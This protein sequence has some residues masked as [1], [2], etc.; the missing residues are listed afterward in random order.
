MHLLAPRG[1][2]SFSKTVLSSGGESLVGLLKTA[3][4]LCLLERHAWSEPLSDDVL[5]LVVSFQLATEE[6]KSFVNDLL[7]NE[8]NDVV[9]S[10]SALC[11]DPLSK[12][13]VSLANRVPLCLNTKNKREMIVL[14]GTGAEKPSSRVTVLVLT[15]RPD[16]TSPVLSV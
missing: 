8:L 4:E 16:T 12:G 3:K 7:G 2:L 5:A 15:G 11:L 14:P 10:L 6:G 13:L 1:S 9:T